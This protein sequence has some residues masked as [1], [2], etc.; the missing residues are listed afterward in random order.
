M[1]ERAGRPTG[2]LPVLCA[3]YSLKS[4]FQFFKAVFLP[5]VSEGSVENNYWIYPLLPRFRL[6]AR[7]YLPR[8]VSRVAINEAET[9]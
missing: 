6:S 7:Q 4:P 8:R 3:E 1:D 2:Y 9:E 5:L